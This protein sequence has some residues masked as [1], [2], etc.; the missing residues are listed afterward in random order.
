MV[1]QLNREVCNLALSKQVHIYSVD[2]SA[3]YTEAEKKLHKQLSY[4]RR[5]KKQLEEFDTSQ[6]EEDKLNKYN[7]IKKNVNLKISYAKSH[8]LDA[9][10]NF[11]GVR[12]LDEEHLVDRNVISIFESTLTRVLGMETNQLSKEILIVETYFFDVVKQIII[13]GFTLHG[14]KYRYYTASAGQIRTKKNVFI[15]ES[16]WNKYENTLTCGLTLDK[17]NEMGGFNIN[18]YLA[19][20]ALSNSATDLWEDFDI[21]RTIVVDD[22]EGMVKGEVDYIND[23]T[24]QIT[25]IVRDNPIP[26]TDGCGMIRSDVSSKNFMIRMPYVKGLLGSFDYVKFIKEHNCSPI[27][28][29]IYGKEYNII[30]DD[31]QIIFTKSQFKMWSLFPSWKQYKENFKKYN[32]QAG[33][34]KVEEDDFPNS[35]MSYQMFQTLSDITDEEM[36]QIA[37][38][39]NDRLQKLSSDKNT[40]LRVFGATKSNKDRNGFQTALMLY[41]ELLNDPYTKETLRDIKNSLVK[42]YK[43][44]K[45]EVNGKYTFLLPDLYAFCEWLFLGIEEPKGL[46]QGDEVFCRLFEDGVELDVLRSPHLYREHFVSPNVLSKEYKKWFK[47][48][49]IYTSTHSLISRVLQFDV[50]GDTALVVS[51]PLIVE[52]AKR[53]MKGVVPL[54]YEA[55]KANAVHIDGEQIFKG[56]EA[57]WKGGKIGLISNEITK[58]WNSDVWTSDDEEAKKEAETCIKYLCM[59]NNYTIDQ[60]CGR[61]VQ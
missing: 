28:K 16:T 3:F 42:Q 41:P 20:N 27:V 38:K 14:E 4:Y 21:D 8:L 39:S 22:F 30:E 51:D 26:H 11:E 35:K 53:N 44:A 15:K 56:L 32:C 6:Y 9:L 29:D 10:H 52:I 54:Y 40:M 45:L 7:R 36:E 2:T 17:L 24:F 5:K 47:T 23:E 37:S 61:L 1:K 18:K 50:D 12:E 13:N 34:C 49:A 55:R 57:A 43:S 31:I 46:L 60:Q 48:K 59:I 58:I 33:V 25:R 19:Y